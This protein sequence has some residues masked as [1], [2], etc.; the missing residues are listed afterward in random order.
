MRLANIAWLVT[1][2]SATGLAQVNV[3]QQKPEA[4]VPFT[5]TTSPSG[6]AAG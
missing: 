6:M 5:M 1:L 4:S 3:G 2:A